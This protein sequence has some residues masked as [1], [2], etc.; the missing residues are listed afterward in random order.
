MYDENQ[1]VEHE[2]KKMTVRERDKAVSEARM[3]K[4]K[5]ACGADRRS[6]SAY[7]QGCSDKHKATI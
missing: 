3:R 1:L 4:C 5:N 2:G 6:G 7:C